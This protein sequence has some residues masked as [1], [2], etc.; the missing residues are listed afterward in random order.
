MS[1]AAAYNTALLRASLLMRGPNREGMS[2]AEMEMARILIK[3][4]GPSFGVGDRASKALAEVVSGLISGLK[5]HLGED[6]LTSERLKEVLPRIRAEF[7]AFSARAEAAGISVVSESINIAR[8]A[9]IRGIE[10]AGERAGVNRK[11]I[12]RAVAS[13]ESFGEEVKTRAETRMGFAR[14][15]DAVIRAA[16]LGGMRATEEFLNASTGRPGKEVATVLASEITR[17]NEEG[18]GVAMDTQGRMMHIGVKRSII[19]GSNAFFHEGLSLGNSKSPA[20]SVVRWSLSPAHAGRRSSPDV[21]D[22]LATGNWVQLG[23]GMYYPETVPGLPH[24]F[25]ECRTSPEYREPKEWGTSRRS[26]KPP[27]NVSDRA[28]EHVFREHAHDGSPGSTKYRIDSQ[29]R[30]ANVALQRAHRA[31]A[32]Q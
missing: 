5:R 14:G 24:S 3:E 13:F 23:P 9:H 25:C 22:I 2:A 16:A 31:W 20:V 30:F 32:N 6:E 17:G 26:P 8:D 27:R 29:L 21:C 7:A 11:I 19:H 4:I 18:Y 12:E 10:E 15:V 1:W 28:A